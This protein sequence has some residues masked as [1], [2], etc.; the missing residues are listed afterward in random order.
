MALFWV[1]CPRRRRSQHA[2]SKKTRRHNS[3]DKY[4]HSPVTVTR[5][6]HG[7]YLYSLPVTSLSV[8][9][10]CFSLAHQ[11]GQRERGYATKDASPAKPS[12]HP[13]T[14]FLSLTTCDKEYF[15]SPLFTYLVE[16]RRSTS[17]TCTHVK[18][19]RAS[20]TCP[21]LKARNVPPRTKL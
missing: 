12:D 20:N 17:A 15:P 21:Q 1:T 3:S 18:K 9:P 7:L 19:N 14:K 16:L 5:E 13:V 11:G 6:D 2:Y 8:I 4:T 10:C